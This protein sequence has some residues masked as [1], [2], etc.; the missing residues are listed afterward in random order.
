V[1]VNLSI[2]TALTDIVTDRF[3]TSL[4]TRH[5]IILEKKLIEAAHRIRG[6]MDPDNTRPYVIVVHR[7]PR[8]TPGGSSQHGHLLLS[9]V[10]EH[11]KFLD[12][13]WSKIRT[14]RINLELCY[15]L[16]EPAVVGRHFRPALRFLRKSRPEVAVWLDNSVGSNS[17][18][19]PLT[20]S[21]TG[22]AT[23]F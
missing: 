5:V 8:A 17:R 4:L 7:K 19:N 6:E 9:A 22:R 23:R 15:D 18:S 10:D 13:G 11:G 3:T 1:N 21:G 2:N 16:D 20:L 12:D 14:D